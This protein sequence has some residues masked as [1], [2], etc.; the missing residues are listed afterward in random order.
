MAPASER[1]LEM[2]ELRRV[3]TIG[4][5][6]LVFAAAPNASAQDADIAAP[7]KKA[8][9]FFAKLMVGDISGAYDGVF[10]GASFA[11]SNPKLVGQFKNQTSG[12]P[13]V[14]GRFMGYERLSSQ[15]FGD[16]ILR[17]I[18]VLKLELRPIVWEFYF[19][20]AKADW[21]LLD[22]RFNHQLSSL[23][24]SSP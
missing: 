21:E 18:Y 20:R 6:L 22:I 23:S 17:L 5:T 1:E 14:Y 8:E 7:L 9:T 3:L 4:A 19:Y 11:R 2:I 13:S 24:T 10:K 16:S 15:R 12:L